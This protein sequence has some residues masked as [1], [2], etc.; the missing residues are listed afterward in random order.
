M[1]STCKLFPNL[2]F[3]S[4]CSTPEGSE[5]DMRFVYCAAC[6]C[7]I[8]ND[9]SG[10]DKEKAERFIIS[11]IVSTA[12]HVHNVFNV[13]LISHSYFSK[14]THNRR[15]LMKAALSLAERLVNDWVLPMQLRMAQYDPAS[16]TVLYYRHEIFWIFPDLQIF[17][18]HK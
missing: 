9:W 17:L 7:Y 16:L 1:A 10:M 15:L 6:V 3:P 13:L 5:N 11:S 14:N 12:S 18:G 2:F 4:F 8:L